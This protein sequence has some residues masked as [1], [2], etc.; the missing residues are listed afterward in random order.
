MC[1]S[2]RR[3]FRRR[4]CLRGG[5][6]PRATGYSGSCSCWDRARAVQTGLVP[7][8]Q[9][10]LYLISSPIYTQN[11]Q[12]TSLTLHHLVR[13]QHIPRC[14]IIHTSGNTGSTSTAAIQPYFDTEMRQMSERSPELHH[15]IATRLTHIDYCH[16]GTETSNVT[17]FKSL[18]GI[19]VSEAE[20]EEVI[21]LLVIVWVTMCLTFTV[22]NN[23]LYRVFFFSLS[24]M[25]SNRN[26]ECCTKPQWPNG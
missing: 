18:F 1:R 20:P 3:S 8:V 25:N 7:L 10:H 19:W 22:K 15:D 12:Q 16:P 4:L 2:G 5:L 13:I 21:I 11:N 17:V 26:T 23:N 14:L 24:P 9:R 6:C